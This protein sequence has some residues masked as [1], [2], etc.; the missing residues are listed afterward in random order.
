MLDEEGL[1]LHIIHI[2]FLYNKGSLTIFLITFLSVAEENEPPINEGLGD[3][4][5]AEVASP[6]EEYPLNVTA[7]TG[8]ITNGKLLIQRLMTKLK[9]FNKFL[10]DLIDEFDEPANASKVIDPGF[11]NPVSVDDLKKPIDTASTPPPPPL[12]D[13]VPPQPP[14][15]ESE[16]SETE[17][18]RRRRPKPTRRPKPPGRPPRGNDGV[19]G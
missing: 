3:D 15:P 9:D 12:I 8:D 17:S 4:D 1:T 2:S 6:L 16:G 11:N 7:N 18:N 19:R 13:T 5:N 14:L 10:E